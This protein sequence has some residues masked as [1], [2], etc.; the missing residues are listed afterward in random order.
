MKNKLLQKSI[1]ILST[2]A[3]FC[4]FASSADASNLIL[5]SSK[6]NINI[7]EQFYVDVLLD[8]MGASING[9]EGKITFPKDS[10]TFLRA[11]DGKSMVT[12]WIE[13]PKVNKNAITF[14]GIIPNGFDG[15]IDPFN[16]TDKLPGPIIRL[17]FEGKAEGQGEISSSDFAVTL[18]DG[19]GTVEH[20]YSVFAVIEVGS[21]ESP[22]MYNNPNIVAPTLQASVIQDPNL[23]NNKYVLVF[24]AHDKES[25][26]KEVKIKEGNR[27]WKVIDSP[28]LLEDQGRHSI[29]RVQ[30]VNFGGATITATIEPLPY[31][32]LPSVPTILII[33]IIALSFIR[34]IYVKYKYKNKY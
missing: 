14:S 10:L 18:N 8:P 7:K 6:E 34:W 22:S 15:V 25:G 12:L 24:E 21:T 3:L 31:Q 16:P 20:L 5:K 9:I 2:I 26:I 17:V 23:Y 33:S 30:A 4:I 19:D 28:Y 32:G 1:L 27:D 29:I 11:E 13:K